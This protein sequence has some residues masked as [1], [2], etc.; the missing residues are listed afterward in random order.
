MLMKLAQPQATKSLRQ[1]EISSIRCDR[2]LVLKQTVTVLSQQKG[3]TVVRRN[4]HLADSRP[5]D[6]DVN[7]H[8]IEEI[9]FQRVIP[10]PQQYRDQAIPGYY[11]VPGGRIRLAV[12]MR[13]HRKKIDIEQ[14]GHYFYPL[15][16]TKA[17]TGNAISINAPLQ[18]NDDRSQI[19]D[20]SNNGFNAWLIDRA[21]DL[22]FDLLTF[23]WWH[24]FG[25]DS[26]LALQEQTHSA[27][28]YFLKKIINRL[29]K[30]SCWPTRVHEKGSSKHPQL[31]SATEIVI[32]IHHVLDGFLSDDRLL[33]DALGNNPRIQTMVKKCGAKTFGIN[34]LVR[35]RCAGSDKTQLATKLAS[36]QID[37]FYTNFPDV[38][39]EESLQRKFAHAFDVLASRLSKQNREDLKKTPTTL[40]AD[41]SLQAPEKLW[42]VDPAIASAC[43][44]AASEQL[45]PILTEYKTLVKLCN[46][47]D[48]KKWVQK[49]AQHVQDGTASEDQR[50]A[51]Y[52]FLLT[53]HGHL[54]RKTWAMLRK[55]PVLRD[56]K[57]QWIMPKAITLRKAAGASQLEAALHFP[58]PDYE[59]DKVL[60]EALRFKTKITGEDIVRYAHLYASKMIMRPEREAEEH[61]DPCPGQTDSR[62]AEGPLR[63][64]GPAPENAAPHRRA[65]AQKCCGDDYASRP[66]A[67]HARAIQGGWR[68]DHRQ[69]YTPRISAPVT[70]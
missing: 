42:V 10:F 44:I 65:E 45:H 38:L 54:D 41:G 51:L 66:V 29:E 55:T 26:Y 20:P 50:T 36:G 43:S 48:E 15:G 35:L 53:K 17:Y 30:D 21:T 56:H 18:I 25:P 3:I 33:D 49:T 13:K 23:Y 16:A 52:N 22:T 37:Q 19:I 60:A 69:A 58:H 47:Y 27:S 57:N 62:Y 39:K 64:S 4:I 59:N 63:E 67:R 46:K 40:A 8:T 68:Q 14:P 32:P 28:T 24:K 34:S 12:S 5:I 6:S 2:S 70:R 31:T 61:L 9:E 7:G 1:L 11:N